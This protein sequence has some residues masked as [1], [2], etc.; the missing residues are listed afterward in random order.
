MQIILQI[1]IFFCP[2]KADIIRLPSTFPWVSSL[3]SLS[4]LEKI[5]VKHSIIVI[6]SPHSAE[7]INKFRVEDELNYLSENSD[8]SGQR[9]SIRN[10]S[11]I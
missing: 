2:L 7:E 11:R 5:S 6:K 4:L 1:P 10:I 8:I 3:F 9:Q